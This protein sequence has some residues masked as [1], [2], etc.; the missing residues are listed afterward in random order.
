MRRFYAP[1]E[2]FNGQKISLGAEESKHL[3]DV[4]RDGRQFRARIS[5]V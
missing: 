2:S 4:L 3:R 1:P 5:S